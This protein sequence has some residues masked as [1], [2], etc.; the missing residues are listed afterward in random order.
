MIKRKTE[1]NYPKAFLATGII[2]A[3]LFAL[4]YFIVFESPLV[5][6]Q[7]TGGILVNYGTTDEGEGK[8]VTS[9]EEPSA[10]P[11]ANKSTP[12]K[13]T[14]VQ[15]T[16]QKSKTDNDDTKVVTQN[17]ED[18]AEVAANA[19]KTTHTIN[20]EPAN[21]VKKPQINQN[22]LYHGSTNKGQGAGDGTSTKTGNQGSNQGSTLTN[23]YGP[24][25]SGGG[26]NMPNWSFVTTPDVINKNRVPGRVV[27]DFTVDQN[28]N[29]IN[30]HIVK[31]KSKAEID[32][33]QAC[34]EAIR[35]SKF[36]SSVPATG[37]QNGEMTFVFKVD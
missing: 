3:G 33:L 10:S 9:T 31:G 13:V 36:K 23:N 8:D 22:A 16:E 30:A 35:N 19:K 37:N 4:C 12:V 1:N 15:P 14:D 6:D 11:K 18:A 17:T 21:T 28:G 34:E 32:L 7:G 29:V 20:T 24:G 25:G 2:L 26:L 5:V 27:V